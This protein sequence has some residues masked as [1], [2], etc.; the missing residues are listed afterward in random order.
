[1]IYRQFEGQRYFNFVT[2]LRQLSEEC[3][4]GELKDSLIRDLIICGLNDSRLKERMLR[5]PDLD[6]KKAIKLGQAVKEAMQHK[7]IV[8]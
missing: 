1:M 4:F 2:E 6:L 7:R 3:E 8:M 5:E